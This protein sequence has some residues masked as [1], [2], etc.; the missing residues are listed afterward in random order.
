MKK[1]LYILLVLP[2]FLICSKPYENSTQSFDSKGVVIAQI[3]D[4]IEGGYLFYI[5]ET[6]KHG[7][8]PGLEDVTEGACDTSVC[9]FNGCQWGCF[10]SDVSRADGELIGTE[11]QN[12]TDIFAQNCQTLNRGI[13]AVQ[14]ALDYTSDG[15]RDWYLASIDEPLEM[16]NTVTHP[17]PFAYSVM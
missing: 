11:Y 2:L 13:T 14:A 4:V 8:G 3:G 15:Y 17:P 16:Y 1:L 10:G 7:L 5:N 12:T 6:G 9:S